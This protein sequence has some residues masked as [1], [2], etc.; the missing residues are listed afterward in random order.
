MI[1]IKRQ[2]SESRASSN[3]RQYPS[4]QNLEQFARLR[5]KDLTRLLA[6]GHT[7]FYAGLKSG[8]YPRPDGRDGKR[9]YWTVRSVREFLTP[10]LQGG[11]DD[12]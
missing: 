5:V 9:P 8:R 7:Q 2:H 4:H 11:A 3:T 12:E 10:P 6:V 1:A